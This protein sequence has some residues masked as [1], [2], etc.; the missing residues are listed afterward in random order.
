M[1]IVMTLVVRD[2]VDI[3]EAWLAYHLARGVDLV[4]ATDHRSIDGTTDILRGTS[5]TGAS[6]CC[7]R[8]ATILARRSG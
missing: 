1:R 8:K 5:A 2:E 7:A 6:S 3:V 4:I